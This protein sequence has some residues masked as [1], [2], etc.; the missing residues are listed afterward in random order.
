MKFGR[1]LATPYWNYFLLCILLLDVFCSTVRNL[2]EYK[3]LFPV[4]VLCC[5]LA[6]RYCISYDVH[7]VLLIKLSTVEYNYGYYKKYC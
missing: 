5:I 7:K 1:V 4:V 2:V 3:L 6:I